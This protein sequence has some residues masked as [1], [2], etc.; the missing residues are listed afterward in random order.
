MGGFR[1]GRGSDKA[2]AGAATSSS[3][4]A[5]S[6]TQNQ[7]A[8]TF[9]VTMDSGHSIAA[10]AAHVITV[11]NTEVAAD[12]TISVSCGGQSA[13]VPISA[14]IIAISAG[15]AFKVMLKNENGSGGAAAAAASTFR[16]SWAIV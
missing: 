6:I 15:S 16:I 7:R 9:I 11:A 14:A 4:G 12:D 2:A 1:S 10:Q 8:G 3:S 13:N 5:T